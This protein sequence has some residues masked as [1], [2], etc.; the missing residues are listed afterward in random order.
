[1]YVLEEGKV[2]ISKIGDEG[3]EQIVRF[4]KAGDLMGYRALLSGEKYRASATA[5]TDLK[6][7]IIPKENFM[8]IL[9]NNKQLS[10]ELMQKLTDDFW[11]K[12]TENVHK[13]LL[14]KL[15]QKSI[16]PDSLLK[17]VKTKEVYF[18]TE[19]DLR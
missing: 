2:K 11:R 4:A 5:L 1:M 10:S 3:K 7:C 14:F 15:Q 8:K 6:V 16:T 12:Y 19:T 18:L 13:S 9:D 17:D